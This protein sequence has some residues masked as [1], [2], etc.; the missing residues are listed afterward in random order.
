MPIYLGAE[1]VEKIIPK[2]CFIHMSDF[3]DISDI[4]KYIRHLPKRRYQDYLEHIT[5]F[6]KSEK[7]RALIH[8]YTLASRLD[9]LL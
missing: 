1:N 3:K 5:L 6:Y 8:P 9:L 4:Y 2:E 7:C